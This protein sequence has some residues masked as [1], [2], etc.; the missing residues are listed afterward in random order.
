MELELKRGGRTARVATHGGELV[1]YRDEN[2]LE[3][4]W[5]GDPA[6]WPGR[7][8]LLFPI[9]GG[10]KDGKVR[11]EGKEVSMNRHGFART[12]EF[13]V[14]GQGEDWAALELR[15][16][17]ATLALYPYP[18]Q[19]T[20][21]QQLTDTGF[22]TSVTVT[23]TGDKPM[24]FCLG[25]H[26]GFRCPLE[27][28]EAFTDYEV[29]FA[30]KETCPTL[31]PDANGVDRGRTRPCLED[32]DVLPL[33]YKYFDEMDTLIFEGLKS[34]Q[35]ELHSKKTGKGVRVR[36]HDFPLL[37]LWSM[38]GKAAPYLCIEP[39]HGMSAVAG[40]GP[41]LADKA[42]CI[43]LA[44]GESRTLSYQVDTL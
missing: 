20:V 2:G 21:R 43:T 29:R 22:T 11:I 31:V 23:N 4:I 40:E 1:S 17:G 28:G 24:P 32:A 36:F 37:A 42:Y 19:L 41:E 27:E 5:T 38:P 7:N 6:Y 18:F 44:P 10:L 13:S 3:Y 34:R 25:A 9:V 15:E 8:P 12:S 26:T 35:V 33:D 30:Q 16:S 39:W 14:V